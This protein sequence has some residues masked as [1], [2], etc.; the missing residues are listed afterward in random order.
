MIRAGRCG[1]ASRSST[2]RDIPDVR[3]TVG[4]SVTASS[5]RPDGW[6]ELTSHVDLDAGRYA[7]RHSVCEAGRACAWGSRVAYLVDNSGNLSS[8]DLDVSSTRGPADADFMTVKG[9]VKGSKMEIVS[10]GKVSILRPESVIRLRAAERGS[11]RARAAWT[12]FPGC[13][14]ASGGNRRVINPISG[15]V[16]S[17]RVE[18]VRRGTHSLGG[19]PGHHVRGRAPDVAASDEDVGSNRRSDLAPGDSVSVRE[20]GARAPG[21]VRRA[22][23]HR[24]PSREKQANDR[25]MRRDQAVRHQVRG[26]PT[27]TSR[28]G[29]ASSSHFLGPTERARRRRSR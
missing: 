3:R 1:G 21:R 26:R 24:A 7:Q 29:R 2:I 18:V 6:F 27:S 5:R 14:W 17:V 25:T 10:R 8:F 19:Q 4:E 28:S 22:S 15:Q 13:T 23:T 16:E 12:G 9:K 11:R 20:A